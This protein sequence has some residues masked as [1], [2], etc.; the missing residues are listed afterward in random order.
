MGKAEVSGAVWPNSGFRCDPDDR[1]ASAGKN[2]RTETQGGP[3]IRDQHLMESGAREATMR[4][5]SV[6]LVAQGD[7]ASLLTR[8]AVLETRHRRA[9]FCKNRRQPRRTLV[10]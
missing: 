6:N 4:E 5:F 10:F 3:A 9:Q 1:T 8:P 2:E 7:A